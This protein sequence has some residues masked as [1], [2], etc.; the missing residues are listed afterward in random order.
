L[1]FL[2][3]GAVIHSLRDE[4]DM[5][6]MGG[7]RKYMPVTAGTFIV[8]WLAI[9]G[10]VPFAG[11]WSKDEILAKTWFEGE[12]VLWVIGA[13]TALLTAFYMTR[14][15][16]M[17]FY[18]GE[19]WRASDHVEEPAEAP[20]E[21]PV[22]AHHGGDHGDHGDEPHDAPWTMAFPLV[23]LA[24]LSIVGG[25]INLP[26]T[27]QNLEFLTEWLH[28]V[29]E[30][31]PEIHAASFSSGFILSTIA[32]V[33]GVVG[34]VVGR[35]LYKQGLEPDGTD[36]L[37]KRLG[38]FESVLANAY[39]LDVGLARFVSGPVTAFAN[40]VARGFDRGVI[41]GAVNGIATAL[42]EAGTG[43]RRAQ[44]GLVRN[45][46]LGIVFGAVALMVWFATRV[47]L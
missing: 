33:I 9:A 4:Q 14:Q 15:V 21:E 35:A 34:I 12:Y 5:R 19:R 6:R 44:T 7:L 26:F 16:Y 23:V 37:E 38:P 43:L 29:F 27:K 13:V 20:A 10:I 1:L 45:Y 22:A 32:L 39:Y 31:V 46:A 40:F 11:F 18:D 17:V 42:R 41:D 47:T 3:A 8:G 2:G 28:P 30:D 36:P 25:L 24:A